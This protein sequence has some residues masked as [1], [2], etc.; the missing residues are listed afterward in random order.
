M[1]VAGVQIIGAT[2]EATDGSA[3]TVKDIYFDGQDWIVRY[4]VID[5]GNWLPG[6]KVLL[7]PRDITDGADW[8]SRQVT[9]CQTKKQ[10][11]SSPSVDDDQPVS[12]QLEEELASYYGWPAYW[13]GNVTFG[14]PAP[15][16]VSR[17]QVPDE[18]ADLT[19]ESGNGDPELRSCREV[20][21]YKISATDGEIGQLSDLIVNTENWSIERIVVKTGSWF[22]LR[23]LL[24][25]CDRIRHVRWMDSAITVSLSRKQVEQSPEFT[26]HD[27]NDTEQGS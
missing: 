3:G 10:I 19:R 27:S 15:A 22:S 21:D 2:V 23:K 12:R 7:T 8:N 1:E 18:T 5:T 25:P 6:R 4:L 17:P 11:E 9:V 20:T 26:S 16:M 14:A 13:Q 24:I